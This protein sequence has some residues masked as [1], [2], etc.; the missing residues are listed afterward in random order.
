MTFW[1]F[2]V[3]FSEHLAH[4]PSPVMVTS[5]ASFPLGASFSS[6]AKAGVA[7]ARIT[8]PAMPVS[9]N[10]AFFIYLFVWVYYR[11]Y[12]MTAIGPI[13]FNCKRKMAEY[14]AGWRRSAH[15]KMHPRVHQPT[16]TVNLLPKRLW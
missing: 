14:E 15:L 16:D 1:H 3:S 11:T 10:V 9:N 7:N 4:L 5:F 2:S 8:N 13:L 6:A 12:L